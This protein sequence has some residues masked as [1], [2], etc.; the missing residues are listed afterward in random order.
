MAHQHKNRPFSAIRGEN[1]SKWDNQVNEGK[2]LTGS[3]YGNCAFF[4]PDR[5]QL[6]NLCSMECTAEFFGVL[7]LRNVSAHCFNAKSYKLKLSAGLI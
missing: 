1:R 7:V 4:V 5:S 6:Y 3:F 2:Y